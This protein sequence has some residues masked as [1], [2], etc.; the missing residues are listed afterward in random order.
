[1]QP[2]IW[3][4]A[5]PHWEGRETPALV[6]ANSRSQRIPK[7]FLNASWKRQGAVVANLARANLNIPV[8]VFHVSALTRPRPPSIR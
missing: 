6:L 7:G 3:E 5:A 4:Q 2:I 1:M 8:L